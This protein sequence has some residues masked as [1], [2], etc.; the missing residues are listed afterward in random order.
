M[1][2]VEALEKRYGKVMA[3]D[4]LSF[5]VPEGSI[6]GFVGPNG[7]GK[8]TTIKVLATLLKPDGGKAWVGGA[9]VT[10]EPYAV[11]QSLG[12]MPD[13]FGVYDNL[14]SLEYLEFYAT[15]HGISAP[16]ARAV[17]H[18]LLE[19]MDLKSRAHAYVDGLSRGMKQKLC[20]ARALVHDPAVLVLDEPASGLDPRARVEMRELLKELTG[21]GKTIVISSHILTELS[22]LC[23]H[24]GIVSNGRLA[25]FGNVDDIMRRLHFDK[26][27]RLRVLSDPEQAMVVVKESPA[28]KDVSRKD[29]TLSIA[30][31]GDEEQM[32]LMLE[33][34]I[35]AG[36][37][38][39][40]F[41]H[42]NNGLEEVFMQLTSGGD[43]R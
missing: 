38:V 9:E 19:L 22:E 10:K 41:S 2:R 34:L 32:A 15:S 12:Y 3:L 42:E 25:A 1:I 40:S 18:D 11:K 39:I 14:T 7:A 26:V 31:D 16:N 33:S 35:R 8:T 29:S 28:V 37:R 27:L 36:V 4:G 13:F 24:V 5:T 21:M 23:T 20:L 43:A 6:F 30:F 17:A